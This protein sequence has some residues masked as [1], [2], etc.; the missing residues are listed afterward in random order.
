[1]DYRHATKIK[2]CS[3]VTLKINKQI[4]IESLFKMCESIYLAN[5]NMYRCDQHNV[6]QWSA[7]PSPPVRDG[8]SSW[9]YFWPSHTIYSGVEIIN[10]GVTPN[11]Q[12]WILLTYFSLTR[13][14][15]IHSTNISL[16]FYLLLD[17]YIS[18]GKNIFI[19][20][21][22]KRLWFY[23]N[24]FLYFILTRPKFAVSTKISNR[25]THHIRFFTPSWCLFIQT[26]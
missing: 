14:S 6:L 5:R 10:I 16:R 24:G 25:G 19:K 11:F 1:M 8:Q 4:N 2:C 21:I 23:Y 9:P 7:W 22:V 18:I 26:Q 17:R 3:I 13:L 12:A 15:M 20:D